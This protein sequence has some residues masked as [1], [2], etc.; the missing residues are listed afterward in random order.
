MGI[1]MKTGVADSVWCVEDSP[2][3]RYFSHTLSP[4]QSQILI[5]RGHNWGGNDVTNVR[6][7]LLEIADGTVRIILDQQTP[8]AN[9][10]Y[11]GWASWIGNDALLVAERSRSNINDTISLSVL[12]LA[13]GERRPVLERFV[14]M[15]TPREV[16]VSDDRRYLLAVGAPRKIGEDTRLA[17]IIH[18]AVE[19]RADQ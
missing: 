6:L 19:A 9:G 11:L 14:D 8:G 2:G 17:T 15:F 10:G 12:D 7:E 3:P 16:S 1:H 5:E 13:S 4:D 18:R